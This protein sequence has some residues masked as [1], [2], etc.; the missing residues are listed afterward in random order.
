MGW[1]N[2]CRAYARMRLMTA[3]TTMVA[4][5]IGVLEYREVA[6]KVGEMATY[7][8]VWKHAMEGV[9]HT[10]GPTPAGDWALGPGRGLHIWFAMTSS[11]MVEIM[12]EICASGV[13]M[14]PSEKD[15]ANP[16]IR[17]Y[18]DMY[19]RGKDVDVEHKSR[20][21]RLAHDLCA[22]SFAVRQDIYEY[23]HGGDPSRNRINLLRG[24][25]QK[26]WIDQVT[27]LISKPLPHGEV[28]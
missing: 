7:C 5:A 2:M 8:E 17:K 25:D 1:A 18:L 6:S 12:R 15:L 13:V 14:Q 10:S 3:V 22:S 23:W 28:M 24:Y 9:E 19:M 21:F 26:D 20:L 11:R 27:D 4:E 16:E